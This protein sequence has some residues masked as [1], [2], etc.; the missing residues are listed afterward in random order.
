MPQLLGPEDVD[1]DEEVGVD[2]EVKQ[3]KRKAIDNAYRSLM[4]KEITFT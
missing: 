3:R 2:E 4:G 1:E